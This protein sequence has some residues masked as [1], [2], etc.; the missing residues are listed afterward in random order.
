[1]TRGAGSLIRSA[2]RQLTS[3][4]EMK[5]CMMDKLLTRLVG[6]ARLEPASGGLQVVLIWPSHNT[7]Y[8]ASSYPPPKGPRVPAIGSATCGP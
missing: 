6:V 7:W 5:G 3:A 2:G 4:T 8:S 1:M